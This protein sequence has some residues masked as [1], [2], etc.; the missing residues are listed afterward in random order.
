M[1]VVLLQDVKGTGK[2]DEL[3]NVAD[4]YARNYLIPRKLAEPATT[5]AINAV[6]SKNE[7]KERQKALELEAAQE[8]AR[9]LHGKTFIIKAKSGGGER[10]FGSVTSKEIADA[11]LAET[12]REIDK[13]KIALDKDIKTYGTY[14][15]AIKLHTG[16]NA[17]VYILVCE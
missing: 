17:D 13:R 6:N 7:A 12:G 3:V 11:I 4:G 1:K 16:V 14:E 10:L 15:A 9:E 8:L 2:K 5:G